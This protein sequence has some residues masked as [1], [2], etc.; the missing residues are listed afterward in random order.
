MLQ[1]D[2]FDEKHFAGRSLDGENQSELHDE[3][4]STWL[5][6]CLM[7]YKLIPC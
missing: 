6:K 1:K 3:R 7:D 2:S 5:I 4:I